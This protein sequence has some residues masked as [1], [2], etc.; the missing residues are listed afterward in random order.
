M[1]IFANNIHQTAWMVFFNIL[2]VFCNYCVLKDALKYPFKVSKA[3]YNIGWILCLL[4]CLFSF[5]G[6]DWF[7]Y[8]ETY[9]FIKDGYRTNLEDVYVWII[10]N[11]SPD[12]LFFRLVVWGTALFLF[13]K[14]ANNLSVSKELV[15][16]LFSIIY[17]IWFAY[18]RATLAMA[19][20]F[21]GYSLI[22]KNSHNF[23]SVLLGVAILLSS[24]FFHK[25]AVFA[26]G[27]VALALLL[28]R[29]PRYTIWILLI[30]F[31]LLIV[32]AKI[33]VAS[34]MLT[35]IGGDGDMA[36]YMAAGQRYMEEDLSSH[37]IGAF[38]QIM[39][40]RIPYYLTAYLGF[41]IIRQKKII[42]PNDIKAFIILQILLVLISSIFAFDLGV[43]TSTIYGRFLRFAAIP[44]TI[45][46]AYL[47]QSGYRHKY[48]KRTIQIAA[49]GTLY[50]LLYSF[51]N[52][53]L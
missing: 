17:I 37:G 32:L 27:V 9:V 38:L 1:F 53:A 52:A 46:M 34:F 21:Y 29:Y 7:H 20:A 6:T 24:Y 45:V 25:T 16:L 11:I 4:F 10:Q 18:A 39:L 42:I 50:A 40:E 41:G 30:A 44:T 51:Y 31:P 12:Y 35:D 43:N 47:Y 49:C 19:M 5:W 48:V 33:G 2:I 13:I 14:T 36:S 3:K 15:L 26:I 22:I 8:L 28:K 23:I